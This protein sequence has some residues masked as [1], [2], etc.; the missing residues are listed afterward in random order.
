MKQDPEDMLG[1]RRTESTPSQP[2]YRNSGFEL[3]GTIATEDAKM[4]HDV[5]LSSSRPPPDELIKEAARLA[6]CPRPSKREVGVTGNSGSGKSSCIYSLL[7]TE[8]I[9]IVDGSGKAVTCFP[10]QYQYCLPHQATKYVVH[11]IFPDECK[12]DNLFQ[13]FLD[14][15]NALDQPDQEDRAASEQEICE[16][17]SR[18]AE[19]TFKALFGKMNGFSIN[20]LRIGH[21]KVT[22]A[23]ARTNL[24]RWRQQLSWPE[25][26]DEEGFWSSPASSVK[27]LHDIQARFRDS[28]L[29]P[30]IERL[31]I[32]LEAPLLK[33]GVV[34]VDLPGFHDA[35]FARVRIARETQAKCDDLLVV[36]NIN[37]AVDNPN[38][39]AI[40]KENTPRPGVGV[41]TLQ[42]VTVVNT[43]SAVFE[44]DIEQLADP[45]ALKAAKANITQ[46]KKKG[47]SW[48]EIEDAMNESDNIVVRARNRKVKKDMLDRYGS[49]LSA[50]QFHV[51][52]VDNA[53][54]MDRESDRTDISEIPLLQTHVQD[55][56]ARALFQVN[57]SFIGNDHHA[58]YYT[59]ETWVYGC[60]PRPDAFNV[61]LP[62]PEALRN[63]HRELKDWTTNIGSSFEEIVLKPLRIATPRINAAA[64]AVAESW[65]EVHFGTV[66]A[67][68]KKYGRH[69]TKTS[70][71]F[72][73]NGDLIDCF[74]ADIEHNW[75][76]FESM[77]H[78]SLLQLK[79]LISKAF[80]EY[81]NLC[82]KLGAPHSFLMSLKSRQQGVDDAVRFARDSFLRELGKLKRKATVSHDGSYVLD[83]MLPAYEDAD[84]VSGKKY[85]RPTV[86]LWSDD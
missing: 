41:L 38:L 32:F 42:T 78:K 58:M 36:A 22:M 2:P 37:R 14:D 39:Q 33:N 59:F 5:Y 18:A 12:A 1:A 46:L 67:I 7:E 84:E 61:I 21:G 66:R 57:D 4:I 77:V 25:G 55:L 86:R 28:G 70:R 48:K 79:E 73:W 71:N 64:L 54:F 44:K 11:C 45:E 52:C 26:M 13:T 31:T 53:L 49:R 9:A 17:K 72:D 34:S 43:H 83:S 40:V 35:N 81:P 30:L 3:A 19:D 16:E 50:G 76:Q 75:F 15:M 8:G 85:S 24:L 6:N 65:R 27:D 10:V 80:Q 60:R 47:A 74:L 20:K 68:C 51:F 82:S 63:F 29:W 69:I 62:E 56:P 23:S